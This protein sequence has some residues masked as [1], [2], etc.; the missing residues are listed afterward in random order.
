M[1]FPCCIRGTF[2]NCPALSRSLVTSWTTPIAFT[3]GGGL[4]PAVL[5]YMGQVYS[6]G[7]GITIAG[8]MMILGSSLVVFLDLLDKMEEG[9]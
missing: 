8:I 2:T 7:M 9:C 4:Y 6:I 3:I 5:G 1:F